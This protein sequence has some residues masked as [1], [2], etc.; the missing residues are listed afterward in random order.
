[1]KEKNMRKFSFLIAI[2]TMVSLSSAQNLTHS[3]YIGAANG[4]NVGGAVGVGVELFINRYISGSFAIGSIHPI[5][6][7][8]VNKSKFDLDIGLKLY[9]I[10]YL[11]F[12]INYGLIDYEYSDYGYADGSN[13]VSYKK[14][15]GFSFT[16]GGRTPSFKNFYLSGFLG[17]TD[18]DKVNHGLRIISDNTLIPRFGIILGYCL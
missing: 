5:F 6:K 10:K 1:M 18:N 13:D 3:F 16:I 14:T 4:T 8:K 7:E 12:G 17:M 2:I 11:Y 15:R 9:L